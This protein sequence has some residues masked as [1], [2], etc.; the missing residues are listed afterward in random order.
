M[1]GIITSP[2]NQPA[3]RRGISKKKNSRN[4]SSAPERKYRNARLL[5]INGRVFLRLF[6]E[7]TFI[8][9]VM[10]RRLWAL[11]IESRREIERQKCHMAT[12]M[13]NLG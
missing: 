7:G 9:E 13:A 5:E 3:A 1:S 10:E 8:D 6:E 4:S 2:R 12:P 11:Y